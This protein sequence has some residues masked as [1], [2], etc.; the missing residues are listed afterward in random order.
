M[1]LI[2]MAESPPTYRIRN[3]DEYYV[4][5]ETRKVKQLRWVPITNR[6]D[7]KGYRRILKLPDASGT[8]SAWILIL[9]IASRCPERG[10]LVDSDGPLTPEDLSDKTGFPAEMFEN[11]LKVL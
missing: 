2:I 3:W 6:H 7:G 11:A 8:F 4:T 5:A 9:Q 1:E 10:K